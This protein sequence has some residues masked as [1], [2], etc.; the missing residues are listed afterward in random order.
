[1]KSIYPIIFILL[2]QLSYSQTKF[3]LSGDYARFH[4]N[5]SLGYLEIYYSFNRQ[6]LNINIE[7]NHKFVKGFL[8]VRIKDQIN[9]NYIINKEYKFEY[10]ISDSSKDEIENS[11]VGNIGFV[12]PFGNYAC[13]M[14]AWDYLDSSK[15][16]SLQFIFN[17]SQIQ[18]N[19]LFISDIEFARSIK[20]TEDTSYSPF[21]KNNY[22]VIPNP[23]ALYGESSSVVNYYSEIYN[24]L[25]GNENNSIKIEHSLYNAEN[26]LSY[27]KKGILTIKNRSKVEIGMIDIA[28][29]TTGTYTLSISVLN[30]NNKVLHSVSKKLFIYNPTVISLDK[31][32]EYDIS[33]MASEYAFINDD[34]INEMFSVSTYIANKQEKQ[35]WEKIS[36][37]DAKKKFLFNFWKLRDTNPSTIDNEFKKEYFKKVEYANINFSILQKKGWRT[38]RGRFYIV[39]GV[40]DEIERYPN[41]TDSRPHEIWFYNYIE[42][43]T[44]C[45]F[46]DLSGFGDYRL[47]HSTIRGELKDDNWEKKVATQ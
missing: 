22:E 21:I 34:E 11:I 6:H 2:F 45:V 24:L 23:S 7:G 26:R 43:G 39:Y 46:A 4:Y 3:T 27:R 1:M 16:D 35:N 12:L 29:Y 32:T 42:G 20:K 38:D 25:E 18:T 14:V 44:M 19:K 28:K 47:I 40:P 33:Y 13:T 41:Q 10:L 37:L 9:Q 30:Q 17:I 31:T 8:T 15:I 5:D 36:D